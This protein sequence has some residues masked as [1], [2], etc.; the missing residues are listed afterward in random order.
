[1]V[2]V[3]SIQG[4]GATQGTPT[5]F[6]FDPNRPGGPPTNGNIDSISAHYRELFFMMPTVQSLDA[7]LV[8]Y[9][10]FS[11]YEMD[12]GLKCVSGIVFSPSAI[13]T[14]AQMYITSF[15]GSLGGM[16]QTGPPRFVRGER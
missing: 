6:I 3:M 9:A 2:V 16:K 8:D 10:R 11:H 13:A 4:K 15:A 7:V 14:Q 1:M 5:I 12:Y